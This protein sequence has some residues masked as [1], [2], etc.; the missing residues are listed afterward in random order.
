ML[1]GVVGDSAF[2]HGLKAYRAKYEGGAAITDE[3]RAS[4]ESAAGTDLRGFFDQWVFGN[5]WPIYATTLI[6]AHD[7][8][9]LTLNQTQNPA[10]PTFVMPVQCRF[11]HGASDTVMVLSDTSRSERFVFHLPFPID[12][13]KLDP[14][15]WILKRMAAVPT[16][17]HVTGG[18]TP[19]AFFLAQNWP[20]PF[21]PVTTIELAVPEPSRVQL[22]VYDALG[23]EVAVLLNTWLYAG[24]HHATF[25]GSR[26]ASGVYFARLTRLSSSGSV[27]SSIVRSMVLLR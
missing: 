11:Y 5:G 7:S 25:D 24:R 10:W 17:V 23:R 16:E 1:R 27:I 20:N 19:D 21:N 8:T 3:F 9:S 15:G 12:S 18:K 2:F 4:M 26:L 14:Q 22:T 13:V 6:S